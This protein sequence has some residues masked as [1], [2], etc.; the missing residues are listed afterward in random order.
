[1]SDITQVRSDVN[2]FSTIGEA[3]DEAAIRADGDDVVIHNLDYDG[4][5]MTDGECECDTLRIGPTTYCS[6]IRQR[7]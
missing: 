4:E 3:I 7:K 1:M 5:H 2:T 6:V